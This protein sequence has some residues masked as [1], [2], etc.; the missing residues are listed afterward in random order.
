M[1]II[2]FLD[3][4]YAFY[5]CSKQLEV[6]VFKTRDNR[7][8]GCVVGLSS[9][10]V[11]YLQQAAEEVTIATGNTTV[12]AEILKYGFSKKGLDV[13]NIEFGSEEEF[14]LLR[15]KIRDKSQ[16]FPVYFVLKHSYFQSL[17]KSLDS[18][19]MK[20]IEHLIP[21]AINAKQEKLPHTPMPVSDTLFLDKE[22]QLLTL[23][24]LMACDSSVPF[25]VTGP[26]G[27]GK[28]RLLATA[29][30]N[31]LNKKSNRV[32]ICTSHRQSAD[33]YIDLCF[34]PLVDKNCI[35][36]GVQPFRLVGVKYKEYNGKYSQLLI[37]SST[38]SRRNKIK[39]CRLIITTLLTAPMLINLKV[40]PFTHILIDEGAQTREPEAIAPLGLANDKTKI[41]IAGD[42]LQVYNY[43]LLDMLQY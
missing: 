24:K 6:S 43:L 14:G 37:N 33:A 12:H 18:M 20:I 23:K 22:Y 34:G 40:K 27:T 31:F 39:R 17:H 30:V 35:P 42:H 26:F 25:L 1:H 36:H 9:D 41:V 5:R 10:D 8:F 4:V 11:A 15:S 19:N 2:L 16:Y 7:C 32:L 38:N 28:T 13:V 21:L 29:A 3:L